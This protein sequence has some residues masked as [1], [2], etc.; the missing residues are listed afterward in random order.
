M[1]DR[2][3]W[4]PKLVLLA[5]TVTIS[6]VYADDYAIDWFTLDGG[7]IGP[8]NASS[9]DGYTLSGTIGQP[10]AR[11][12]LEPMTGGGYSMVGGLWVVPECLPVPADY[13]SDCDVDQA[14]HAEFEAFGLWPDGW[15]MSESDSC[16]ANAS[17]S[18]KQ[19]MI[20]V[21]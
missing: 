10:D 2:I 8:S 19:G 4:I 11:N 13:D 3:A 14:D 20:F 6:V 1:T 7:G 15:N 18:G 9:G 5:L 12:I 16:Q 17:L 21:R